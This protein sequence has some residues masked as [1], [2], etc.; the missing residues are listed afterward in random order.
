MINQIAL[1]VLSGIATLLAASSLIAPVRRWR[2]HYSIKLV[3]RFAPESWLLK[4][5]LWD[6]CDGEPMNAWAE[7]LVR[8]DGLEAQS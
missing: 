7:E 8:R 2:D 3:A 6:E 5:S 4:Y 1:F